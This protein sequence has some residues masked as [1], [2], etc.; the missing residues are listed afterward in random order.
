MKKY[1]TLSEQV[2]LLQSRGLIITD[3]FAVEN[4]LSSCN[5]HKLTSYRFPFLRNPEINKEDYNTSCSFDNLVDLY[6]QDMKYKYCI[7]L[8]LESIET[9]FKTQL[10]YWLS[11][12][13]D[14]FY[15][16]KDNYIDNKKVDSHLKK[17]NESIK[18]NSDNIHISYFKEKICNIHNKK[19]L[20]CKCMPQSWVAMETITFGNAISI[21]SLINPKKFNNYNEIAKFFD[22]P[23]S[24]TL[25]ACLSEIKRIRNIVAHGDKILNRN[26][27]FPKSEV[28]LW[29]QRHYS[30]LNIL[31]DQNNKTFLP[32]FLIIKYLSYQVYIHRNIIENNKNYRIAF[33]NFLNMSKD[34]KEYLSLENLDLEYFEI[35][36][37]NTS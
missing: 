21:Y 16:K 7:L 26:T 8:I 11:A 1:K 27:L 36:D 13:D 34:F 30:K 23:S 37:K 32:Y 2:K 10:I 20:D 4:F 5:Y 3:T 25:V 33:S 12:N 17:L 15:F 6:Y 9:A 14:R 31:I 35:N 28:V 24:R 29:L 22:I 18:D 19:Y